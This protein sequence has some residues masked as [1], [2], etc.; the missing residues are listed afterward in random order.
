MK[1]FSSMMVSEYF[2]MDGGV[3]VA[4]IVGELD[5]GVLSLTLTKPP[6]N[7]MMITFDRGQLRK[8]G[9]QETIL[10]IRKPGARSHHGE[11]KDESS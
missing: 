3:A 10:P 4:K 2:Y 11:E 5:F 6:T 8:W 7:P 9:F 1:G